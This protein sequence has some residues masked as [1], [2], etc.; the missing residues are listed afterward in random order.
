M[1]ILNPPLS[2][3]LLL[4]LVD[5]IQNHDRNKEATSNE[6]PGLVSTVLWQNPNEE[7]QPSMVMTPFSFSDETWL[8]ELELISI[9]LTWS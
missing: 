5:I 9:N 3:I 2:N 7:G 4:Q 6:V 1:N 8:L